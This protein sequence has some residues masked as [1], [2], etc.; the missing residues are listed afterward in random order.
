MVAKAVRYYELAGERAMRRFGRA[1]ALAHFEHAR[2]LIG[3]LGASEEVDRN[4][5]LVL[6]NIGPAII[7]LRGF[8]DPHLGE[9]FTRTAELARKL[10]DDRSLLDA[11]LGVQ[12]CHFMRA[13]HRSVERYEGEVQDVLSRLAD[14]IAAA[15][16]TVLS[17]A[18]R[19]FRGQLARARGPL[20]EACN[21]LDAADRSTARIVNAPVVGLWAGHVIVLEW[22][23]GAPDTAR[24]VARR[25]LAR[26]ESLRDPFFLLSAL[27]LAALGHMWRREPQDA[28]D[29]A[30]RA[31]KLAPEVGAPT[32]EGRATS[33]YHWAATVLE[34]EAAKAHSDALSTGLTAFLAAGP[35]GRTA[36][37]PCVVEVFARAGRVGEALHELDDAL[38]F[39]EVSDER[40]WA[41]ELHR[42]RGELLKE[43]DVAGAEREMTTALDLAAAQGA[44]AFEL[45]AAMSLTRLRS[46]KKRSAALKELRRIHASFTEGL[47]TIDLLEAKA[48]LD[49]G[50]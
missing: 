22:L 6:R 16:A 8:H 1:E 5:L 28:F 35:Y 44:R 18:A 9:T 11:L 14:P 45:R 43:S 27:T 25:M 39:V 32:W 46:G 24:S 19:L 47:D 34:P 29:M 30:R 3:R 10:G 17:C 15:E 40:A 37:T 41:S 23:S 26:A 49:E 38:R 50:R 48:L 4:E 12:R 20:T 7:A 2:A 33:L 21:V 36:L 31:L 13:D 42:L